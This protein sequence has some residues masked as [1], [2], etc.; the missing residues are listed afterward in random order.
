MQMYLS[1]IFTIS[2]NLAGLPGM[3]MPCGYDSAGMPIGIQLI[4]AP[5]GEETMLRAADAYE[6]SGALARRPPAM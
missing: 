3:S 1:D 6:A 4:G 2:V 5:F